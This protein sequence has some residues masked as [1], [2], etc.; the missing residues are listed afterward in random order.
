MN[1]PDKVILHCADTPDSPKNKFSINTVRHWHTDPKPKGNGWNDIG[2][3]WYMGRDGIWHA[4]RAEEI[5]GAHSGKKGNPDALGLCYEGRWLPTVNQIE[6]F[7]TKYCDIK[8]RF[9][10]T[11]D[12]WYGHYQYKKSKTCPGFSIDLLRA[13]FKAKE[14]S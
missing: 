1:Q 11:A 6:G 9:G 14:A 13:Y 10:I 7:W 12:K 8:A 4:G 5:V 2:Y 3:H